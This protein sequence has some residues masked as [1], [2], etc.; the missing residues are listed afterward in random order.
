MKEST[1][2][3]T[4]MVNYIKRG[5]KIEEKTLLRMTKS[6]RELT[7]ERER[8]RC[9]KEKRKKAIMTKRELNR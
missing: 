5:W 3:E 2:K 4:K 7:R 9:N 1:G 6:K 8:E